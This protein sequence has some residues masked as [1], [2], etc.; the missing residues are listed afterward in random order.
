MHTMGAY[1][2]PDHTRLRRLVSKGFTARRVEGMRPGIQQIVD[3]ILDDID[4]DAEVDAV[5]R[6]AYPLP[7]RVICELLGVPATDLDRWRGWAEDITAPDV[8]RVGNSM[9]GLVHYMIGL[10][11]QNGRRMMTTSSLR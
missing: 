11:E 9:R 2:P 10:I 3:E 5:T 4:G 6:F 8:E 1:H 7:I